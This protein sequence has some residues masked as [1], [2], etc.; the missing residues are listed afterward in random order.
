[1][2]KTD[3]PDNLAEVINLQERRVSRMT[4]KALHA[5]K[6]SRPYSKAIT[7]GFL[8]PHIK[9]TIDRLVAEKKEFKRSSFYEKLYHSMSLITVS[10]YAFTAGYLFAEYG[11]FGLAVF[12]VPIVPNFVSFGYE[13]KRT[14]ELKKGIK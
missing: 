4:R 2:K 5:L 13:V 9:L 10:M 11:P 12:E 7:Y 8:R 6:P 1:M 14:Y 3:N